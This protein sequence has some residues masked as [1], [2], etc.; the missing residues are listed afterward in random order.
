MNLAILHYHL[1]HGGVT[2]VIANQLLALDA[3]LDP[4]NPWRVALL[5][6]GRREGWP[7]DLPAKL[8]A[9]EFSL[10]E[11]P[12]LDYDSNNDPHCMK[13]SPADLIQEF[14]MTLGMLNFAPSETVL[15]FHN[16]SLGKSRALPEVVPQ[17][18]EDGYAILLQI[19]DFIEDFRASNYSYLTRVPPDEPW[20]NWTEALYPQAPNIHYA[21]LNQRDFGILHDAGTDPRCLH[22]LPNPV[23]IN[24]E[25]PGRLEAREKL[26]KLFGVDPQA[27][28]ILYPVR[29]IR[30]KNVGEALLYSAMVPSETVVGLTLPPLNP[31]EKPIFDMWQRLAAELSL[32]FIFDIGESYKMLFGE[33]LVASDCIMTTSI[34]EGFGMVY[35]EAWPAGRPLIGRNL[36]E[37]TSDFVQ[38]GLSYNWLGEKLSVPIDWID[39]NDFRQSFIDSYLQTIE[40]YRRPLSVDLEKVIDDKI[41][42]GFVDFGDLDEPLQEQV[43]RLVCADNRNR[44]RLLECNHWL[45]EAFS[46]R[47]EQAT[48]VIMHNT[49]TICENFSPIPSGRRLFSILKDVASSSRDESSMP[50]ANGDQIIECF[51]DPRRFRLIRS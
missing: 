31:V 6:G 15:H 33:S 24:R 42:D 14:Y 9:I 51:L 2:Q 5:Y 23:T 40:A 18:A 38:S 29:G 49:E 39:A 12:L 48:Q 46:I 27:S 10:N 13:C 3:V 20:S 37:V 4:E 41:I 1:S 32:P 50:L 22:L 16:H 7:D 35:L 45:E 21:V 34:A 25:M 19:H 43:L 30:R 8:K 17:L 11:I 28:F 47:R 36:P 26:N 44:N